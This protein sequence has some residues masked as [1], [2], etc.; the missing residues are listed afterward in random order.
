MISTLA[1]ALL[2]S[3]TVAPVSTKAKPSPQR[4][5]RASELKILFYP[6]AH[7]AYTALLV[8][9]IDHYTGML[10]PD[11]YFDAVKRPEI[12][13]SQLVTTFTVINH[14]FQ[15][16]YTFPDRP[17][18][19]NPC[20]DLNF[21]RAMLHLA[22]RDSFIE[23]V[24]KGFA[25]RIDVPIAAP[26]AAWMNTGLIGANYPYPY[27]RASAVALLE[28]AGFKDHDGDGIRNYPIGWDGAPTD[29]KTGKPVNLDP[30]LYYS[31]DTPP[32]R[33]QITELHAAEMR[34]VGIPVEHRVRSYAFFDDVIWTDYNY[35]MATDGWSVGRFPTY[36]RSWF[37][38]EMWIPGYGG[39]NAYTPGYPDIDE[40]VDGIMYAKSL[41][42]AKEA[43]LRAQSLIMDKYALWI[44]IWSAAGFYGYRNLLGVVSTP[45]TAPWNF[46]TQMNAYRADDPTKPIRIGIVPAPP[47]LNHITAMWVVSVF[48]MGPFGLSP[49][50][51]GL[52]PHDAMIE[53]PLWSQ[54]WEHTTW[55]DGATEKSTSR[56]WI[57]KGSNWIEPITGKVLAP[58]TT[59]GLEF[60]AW[61]H[62]H[63]PSWVRAFY[64]KLH[65]IEVPSPH[66]VDY[67]WDTFSVFSTYLPWGWSR[68]LYAPAWKRPPLATLETKTFV[69]EVN[70]T[71]PGDLALP[72]R[73]LGAPVEA[74]SITTTAPG[75]ATLA[76]YT[77]FNI[78]KGRISIFVDLP[79]GTKITVKYWARG[80]YA[81]YTCGDP[82]IPWS[83]ILIGTGPWYMT[84]LDRLTGATYKANRHYMLE[85]PLLGETDWMYT[86]I[87]GPK[88]RSGHMKITVDD[89]VVATGAYGSGVGGV[90]PPP[91]WIVIADLAPKQ[92]LIDIYDI[93]AITKQYGAIFWSPPP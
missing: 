63:T 12:S 52:N 78:V 37:H 76:K 6:D 90:V 23:V 25:K 87:P 18:I 89:V 4:G 54:D 61:Y 20:N 49:F 73:A 9:E 80:D 21:R 53:V 29:P 11:Q 26:S 10:L 81:G 16:N 51:F 86:W 93:I 22:D 58:F 56:F 33:A 43:S 17:G 3:L 50:P 85:T 13:V 42:D 83:E 28:R 39:P 32:E 72:F 67:H 34:A 48:T 69:E 68:V 5:P 91:H 35:Q 65:H 8:G 30:I 84:A 46:F 45:S 77:Q 70:A 75:Y 7:A 27:S 38:S 59:E 55:M 1:L 40:A 64:A 14:A 15:S 62:F 36:L 82:A 79:D 44:P 71:T 19:R 88:P 92:G 41:E 31:Y 24:L 2:V 60:N 66:Q 74:V 57:N 47:N